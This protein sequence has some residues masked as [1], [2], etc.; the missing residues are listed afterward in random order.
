CE[1]G[2][3]KARPAEISD[4][5]GRGKRLTPR[6]TGARHEENRHRH[7][8]SSN[9]HTS[10]P[11]DDAQG[12]E[13][14]AHGTQ[15]RPS[16]PVPAE[17][18]LVTAQVLRSMTA[19][20]LSPFTATN[21]RGPSG[22]IRMPS[23]IRPRAMRL[24]SFRVAVSRTIR[25]PA[26]R[27]EISADLPSRVSL[28]RFERFVPTLTVCTTFFVAPSMIDTPPSRECALHTCLPSG[29]RSMP[30]GPF[31]TGIKVCTHWPPVPSW[32]I[33]TLSD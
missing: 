23:G 30:S 31:P 9:L 17:I 10:P 7:Q 13:Q 29:D 25:S 3:A 14:L 2:A 11:Q 27:S 1:E 32:I 26:S 19:T 33:E 22:A 21:A 24:I 6:R 15:A 16:G 18:R 8:S 5:R 4:A 28:I 20:L 12:I